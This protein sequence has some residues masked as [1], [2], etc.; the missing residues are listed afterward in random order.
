MA[1]FGE[2]PEKAV[3]TPNSDGTTVLVGD[4]PFAVTSYDDAIAELLAR[5]AAG[6]AT[7]VRLSNAWCVALASRDKAYGKLLRSRGLNLPDGAPIVWVMRRSGARTAERVRG[8]S[9]FVDALDRSQGGDVRHFFLG[10]S[11]DTVTLMLRRAHERFVDAQIAGAYSPAYG[12]LD[13]NC[14]SEWQK[15]IVESRANLVWIGL[16]TPKQDYAAQILADRAGVTVVGV[17]AAFDF[18]AGTVR[19]A[20]EW[21]QQ[22]GF[23]WIFRLMTEP[24]RLWRRY[25]VGNVVFARAVIRTW[26]RKDAG[27]RDAYSRT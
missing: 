15:R 21:V 13:E 22:S 16:G 17:G 3:V 24:R 6:K 10:A 25:L 8:P 27:G 18:F 11:E 23:E 1:S 12:E 19:E 7:A 4:V 2:K 5:A 26:I 14:I 20:P 9:L